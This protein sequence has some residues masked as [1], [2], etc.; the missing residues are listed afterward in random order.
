MNESNKVS[1]NYAA[2]STC[3]YAYNADSNCWYTTV[4]EKEY[5][6]GTYNEFNTVSASET[7]YINAGNTGV[8]QFPMEYVVA[9][10]AKAPTAAEKIAYEKAKISI[11]TAATG[12]ATIELDT[13]IAV[14]D[15]VTI[16]WALTESAIATLENNVL[17]ITN[18]DEET[19]VT[20]TATITC[21][22][23]S[24]TA[25]FEI[26]VAHK[27]VNAAEPTAYSVSFADKANRT[28]FSSSKQ[29]WVQNGVTITNEKASSTS[30]VADYANPARFYKSSSLT[31]AAKGMV[32]IEITCNT[33]SYATALANSIS[34]A[35]VTVTTNDK[36]VTIT[37]KAA[38]DSWTIA[39]LTGGQVRVDSLVVYAA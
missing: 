34:D 17:T 20:V 30:N 21:G 23:E 16:T 32:K 26:V 6:L 4:A 11:T 31:F 2:D 36:V 18:P 12:A 10:E 9:T 15:D 22:D 37:F 8:S 33:S 35:N 27:D 38:T 3:V 7:S 28:E 25:V 13:K 14:Y 29:V 1:V 24:E 5:Y 19:K 39:S